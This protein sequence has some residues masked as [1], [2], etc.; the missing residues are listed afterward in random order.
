M[1]NVLHPKSVAI[2]GA[3]ISGIAASI[4]LKR[5]GLEVTVYE[6]SSQAG[7]IWVF[8]EQVAKYA[9]YPSILPSAGD[10]PEFERSLQQTKRHDSPMRDLAEED[11]QSDDELSLSFAPP[12]SVYRQWLGTISLLTWASRPCYVA[13]KNNVSTIEMETTA[14]AWKAGT[15]EFVPHHVLADYIQGAA[16]A[17]NVIENIQFDTRVTEVVKEGSRW[18]VETA[19]LTGV[20]SDSNVS[21][22]VKDFDALVIATGHYH[23]PNVPE[24]P[25]LAD[26]V[27]TFPSRIWHSKRYRSSDAF[28]GQNVLLVGAGVSSVDIAKDLG[29]VAAAVFQSSRGG[30]YDL[31]SHLLPDN[32]ARVEGIRS[33]EALSGAALSEDGSIPGTVTLT[34]GKKL[35]NIHQIILCTGYHVSFPFMRQYHSDGVEP[36]DADEHVLVTNGQVTHNLH[37]DIFY[38]PDPSLVF[39]GVPYHT[40]TFT[41]FEFQAMAIAAVL[42]GAVSLPSETA[43]RNEYRDR[44]QMKG[45]GRTL[46]SL[47]GVNQEPEYV[48]DL[49]AMVN[50]EKSLMVGHTVRWL[51]AYARRRVRQE[52]LFS[53]KRDAAVDQAIVDLVIGC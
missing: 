53:K 30:M 6:R 52:F 39:L 13:L 28:K 36:E 40:A 35:C 29:G 8:N 11:L 23:A 47:K 37:K 4:H 21:R 48:A 19:K 7:G 31:P 22:D 50:A 27:Q 14:H 46:H 1:T 38:I 42:S 24:M 33:F 44:V 15:E 17:N 25:G 32:A 18:R 5:A 10:S 16:A 3:G 2:V 26:W 49:V 41:L 45:A 43:M 12:G 51:E 34:S 9:A 20:P